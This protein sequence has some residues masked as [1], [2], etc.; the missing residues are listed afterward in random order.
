MLIVTMPLGGIS[1]GTQ[2]IL[3]FNYGAGNT[4]RV[5]KAQ[6]VIGILCLIYTAVLMTLAWTCGKYFILLFSDDSEIIKEALKAIRIST[7]MI[8]PLA[9]QYSIVDG[10]TA[11][12]QVGLS[13][14]LSLWR[15]TIYFIA[16]FVIPLFLV[17]NMIFLAEPISDILAVSMAVPMYFI[18][19][20]KILR[21][22][23]LLLSNKNNSELTRETAQ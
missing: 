21:K 11:L 6:K 1:G 8:L 20:G 19:N 15:K 2:C 13:L 4:N 18:F 3:S 9:L 16:V 23:E 10:F 14:F 5:L 22:R 17:P 7:L 12:G